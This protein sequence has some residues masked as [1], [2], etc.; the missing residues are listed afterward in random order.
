MRLLVC[1]QDID[2]LAEIFRLN[3]AQ[4][5]VVGF[6]LQDKG[7]MSSMTTSAIFILLTQQGTGCFQ[8]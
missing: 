1:N 5:S 4:S 3:P 2:C 8:T 6:G 7:L